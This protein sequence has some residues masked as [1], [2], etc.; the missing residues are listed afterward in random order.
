M[1]KT[2]VKDFEDLFPFE[3]KPKKKTYEINCEIR[4]REEIDQEEAERRL[5][6]AMAIMGVS[7]KRGGI[8]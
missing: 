8:H 3:D 1:S 5:N 4:F 2:D 7:G 6:Q